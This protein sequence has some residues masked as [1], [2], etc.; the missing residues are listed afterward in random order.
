M[1]ATILHRFH[2]GAMAAFVLAGLSMPAKAGAPF[3]PKPLGPV[4]ELCAGPIRAAEKRLAIP[5]QLLA[6]V[7]V[8]ESGRWMGKE[9]AIFAWPWTV[10]SGPRSWFFPDQAQ[11]L[12]HT[13]TLQARGVR[14]IDAGCM[15]VNLGYHGKAFADLEAAFDPATNV[16]YAA[17]F[18]SELFSKRRSWALAVGYYHSATPKL[19]NRYRRKVMALWNKERRR[20]NELHRLAVIA[21]FE[22][23]REERRAAQQRATARMGNPMLADAR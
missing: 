16:A 10:T 23:A 22:K 15:Q 12:A 20:A 3:V 13:R 9:Q 21:K 4:A 14:N 1:I 5:G 6:A 19:Q 17:R 8:A 7:A 18:L 2:A 11:A